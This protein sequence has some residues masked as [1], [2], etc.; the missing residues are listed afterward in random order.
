[1]V[2]YYNDEEAT[3]EAFD[4][5]WFKTGDLGYLDE[6]GF[7]FITGRIKNLII[8][9][10]GKNVS[11]E[12]LEE[13]ILDEISYVEEVIVYD[14]DDKLAAEIYLDETSEPEAKTKIKKDIKNLNIKLPSYKKIA[15]TKIRDE[16]FPKTTSMKIKRNYNKKG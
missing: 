11:A 7:L 9:S 6:D 8:L 12:E 14:D 10:N 13:K 16:A 5:G 1:M 15:K 4:D 3:K 2:G